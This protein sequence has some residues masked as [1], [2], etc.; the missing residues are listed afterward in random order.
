M[1]KAI[2][3]SRL[4]SF[5]VLLSLLLATG[6]VLPLATSESLAIPRLK[7]S[8]AKTKTEKQ[9]QKTQV[10]ELNATAA[11][12]QAITRTSID[13]S[14][15]QI[16]GA[17]ANSPSV[18]AILTTIHELQMASN[19]HNLE[20]VLKHYSTRFVSGDNLKLT[21]IKKLI[22]ET[23]ETF[24]DIQYK[25]QTMEIRVN[26]D[27][28]TVES[29]DTATAHAK[30]DPIISDKPGR[31]N[32]RSRGLLYLHRI[33]DSWEILSDYTLFEMATITY[34]DLNSDLN[35]S[36]STP[37]Q[38]FAGDTYSAKVSMAVPKGVLAIATI[39]QEPLVYPQIKPKD[40]FRSLSADRGSLERIFQANISNNNE[41]VTATVGLTQIG[42]DDED[43][44][45]IKLNGI[46]TIVKRVNVIPKS[47]Y[48]PG[49]GK[50]SLVKTSADGNIDVSTAADTTEETGAGTPDGNDTP[51]P[52][53]VMP[54]T[55]Q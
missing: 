18:S 23:W 31:L 6:M 14:G 30:V 9:A 25:T 20:N 53:Q 55:P 34:G 33:G 32:S 7:S 52:G 46:T 35:L 45:T 42:Q 21:E 8:S 3:P 19:D 22:L 36:L 54:S 15:I 12:S 4:K 28:A 43:R 37:E 27:W 49:S 17:T 29:I 24:P 1:W 51:A 50:N 38:T 5:H 40:K 13:T 47:S 39:S 2:Q 26:Q 44:P 16:I 11:S 41:I 48:K 10:Q